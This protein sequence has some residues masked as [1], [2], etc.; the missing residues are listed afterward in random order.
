[1]QENLGVLVASVADIV[2][3]EVEWAAELVVQV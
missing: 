1:L 2:D 3:S